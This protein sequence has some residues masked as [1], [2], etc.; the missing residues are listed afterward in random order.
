[1]SEQALNPN[2]LVLE[3]TRDGFKVSVSMES[4]FEFNF[5]LVEELEDLVAIHRQ[6]EAHRSLSQLRQTKSN[7]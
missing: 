5:W 2:Q 3:D 4:F 7:R 6:K 1:M